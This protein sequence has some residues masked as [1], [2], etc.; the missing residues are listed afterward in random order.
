MLGQLPIMAV[1]ALSVELAT[2]WEMDASR[3]GWLGGIYFV[4]Y[5]VALPCLTGAANRMDGRIVYAVAALISAV[6]SFS[7]ALFANGFWCALVLRFVAGIGFAGIHIVGMKMLADR[8]VGEPQTR[9]S[10]D[11]TGA[12]QSAAGA[13]SWSLVCFRGPWGGRPHSWRLASGPCCLCRHFF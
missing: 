8:L 2:L 7:V 12:L 11:Y 9:A 3:I 10:A 5:A 1:P 4:G 6:A 13:R